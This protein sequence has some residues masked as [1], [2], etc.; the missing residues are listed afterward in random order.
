[1]EVNTVKVNLDSHLNIEYESS[2]VQFGIYITYNQCD[3]ITF[4]Y[5]YSNLSNGNTYKGLSNVNDVNDVSSTYSDLEMLASSDI[6]CDEFKYAFE[7]FKSSKHVFE[8]KYGFK[9]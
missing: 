1:M 4:S 6:V 9:I 3:Y 2:S 7:R 8:Q 5:F